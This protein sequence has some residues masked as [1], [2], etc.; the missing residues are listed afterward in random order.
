MGRPIVVSVPRQILSSED[1]IHQEH[2]ST[3]ADMDLSIELF[4]PDP[5]MGNGPLGSFLNK[6]L[7]NE[8]TIS[9]ISVNRQTGWFG[10]D[11]VRTMLRYS[12]LIR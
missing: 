4:T 6:E 3:I 5:P 9:V 10:W 1:P 8:S 7:D 2:L 11:N 12:C